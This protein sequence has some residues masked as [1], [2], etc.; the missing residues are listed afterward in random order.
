M[1]GS[2]NKVLATMNVNAS[3]T[4]VTLHNAS[5]DV[6]VRVSALT[7]AGA[8][9]FSPP[10]TVQDHAP[11]P[12]SR[13]AD[14]ASTQALVMLLMVGSLVI[15]GLGFIVSVYLKKRQALAKELGHCGG[16]IVVVDG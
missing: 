11:S 7:R 5:P 12:S 1:R 16:Y 13:P 2:H 10:T 6:S 14:P 4:L 3:M 15:C 8:G 9:P